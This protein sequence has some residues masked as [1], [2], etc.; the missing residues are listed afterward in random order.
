M[1]LTST[2][3]RRINLSIYTALIGI[4]SSSTVLASGLTITNYGHSSLLIKGG[5]HSVL[6]NPFKAVGCAKGLPE[7][8]VKAQIILASSELADEGAKVAKGHFLVKP[9]SYKVKGLQ[10]EGLAIPHDR[11]G[12]RRFGQATLWI[13]EQGGIRLAHLG[14]TAAPIHGEAKVLIGQPDIL[15]IGV[16]GGAKVYNGKE[17]AIIVKELNPHHV[18]PVQYTKR[19][20]PKNCNLTD[21]QPFLNST[22]DIQVKNVGNVF[23]IPKIVTKETLIN[24]MN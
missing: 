17:A 18:I 3:L 13:W 16:G 14:G 5:G 2:V 22:N 8:K 1:L 20:K 4:S 15:I 23:N 12:G 7:P 10:L 24:I 6:I 9:G 19:N 21:I 11:F